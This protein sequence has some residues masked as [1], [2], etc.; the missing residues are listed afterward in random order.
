MLPFYIT[1]INCKTKRNIKKN[2]IFNINL[3]YR[4]IS[5][6]VYFLIDS[7]KLINKFLDARRRRE[8]CL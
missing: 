3:L 7:S 6:I 4:L 2:E 8:T 5:A 1:F